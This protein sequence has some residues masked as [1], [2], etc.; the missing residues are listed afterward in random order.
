MS[1]PFNTVRVAAVQYQTVFDT[2]AN[3]AAT[4]RMI[5]E[6]A[7]HRPQLVVLPHLCNY[8]A[9]P[10]HDGD[11]AANAIALDGPFAQAVAGRAAQHH[12]YIAAGFSIRKNDGLVAAVAL[13]DPHGQLAGQ[14][15]TR[16]LLA[17][18]GAGFAPASAPPSVIET[19]IGNIGLYGGWDGLTPDAPRDLALR[20]AHILCNCLAG[21]GQDEAALHAPARAA[22]NKVWVISANR[23]GPLMPPD[24][25]AALAPS[26]NAAPHKLNG[27]GESQII[28]PDGSALA[29]AHASDEAVILAEISPRVAKDKRRPDGTD[30]FASRRVEVYQT[31]T[32][33]GAAAG[34]AEVR[35]LSAAV[36]QPRN[37][38]PDAIE[39]CAYA[40]LRAARGGTKLIVLPELFHVPYG[41]VLDTAR[42][43]H[44]SAQAVEMLTDVLRDTDTL[45]AT[46]IVEGDRDTG[47]HVGVLIGK[48]GVLLRQPQ[49]HVCGRH[50]WVDVLSAG[51][52]T[53]DTAYGRVCLVLGCDSIYPEMFAKAARL[54]AQ[55]VVV[56]AHFLEEWES[57]LGLPERAAEN[58]LNIIAAT[59]PGEVGVS[60]I[61]SAR[62]DFT[63][64]SGRFHA[65]FDGN[66]NMPGI[67]R[68]SKEPGLTSA[69]IHP[70]AS[71]NK[72]LAAGMCLTPGA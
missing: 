52:E 31:K 4:L 6:A 70:A 53:C 19:P 48:T 13:F 63:L 32:S 61:A 55:I 42:A 62:A 26:I 18:E 72:L 10:Q 47:Q 65:P 71:A 40:A 27:A 29:K 11:C 68:A 28:A 49:L 54:G 3:L 7:R 51:L 17:G 50:R 22:E 35:A 23:I 38:G 67:T 5:D 39:D 57:G 64:W 34:G 41:Q 15:E 60:L 21:F 46:S 43:A 9:W 20:G 66:V 58:H 1:Q 14:S 37:E 25:A 12:C 44:Q 8:P 2:N 16:F 69:V 33:P 24:M 45:V 56:P 36:Y 59:R 30:M